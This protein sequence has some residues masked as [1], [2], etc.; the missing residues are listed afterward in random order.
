[1]NLFKNLTEKV[2]QKKK[3]PLSLKNIF[4]DME[5]TTEFPFSLALETFERLETESA[6]RPELMELLL[7]DI[8]FSSLYATFYEEIL[9]T[10]FQNKEVAV[11]LINRFS[12]DQEQR[13][14][15][16]AEQTQAHLSYVL[17]KGFCP[18]CAHCEN[19]GDV[20]DLV[21][22]WKKQDFKFFATLYMGM[23]TIQY[24]MEH[25]LYDVIPLAQEYSDLTSRQQ[26][27]DFRQFVYD[28]VE[29]KLSL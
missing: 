9:E 13:D 10:V 14:Q 2:T 5:G 29:E 27:L 15:I 12:E 8:I 11:P 1:M 22:Y 20:A 21:A 17:N 26:I 3:N 28:Y 6:S 19:H 16:I 23:Q 24:S 25:I 18:G 7:E 4:L